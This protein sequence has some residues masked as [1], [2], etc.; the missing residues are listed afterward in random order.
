LAAESYAAIQGYTVQVRRREQVNGQDKPEEV[1]LFKFR[2]QPFSV[3]FKWV[4]P[5]GKDREAIY[6]KG[7]HDDKLHTLLAA[8]DMPFMPAGKRM[9]LSP[10]S[11]F[12][13]S[14][15]RHSVT[16][17]GL[18]TLIDQFG[19]L[20]APCPPGRPPLSKYLGEV[21]RPEFEAPVI[22]VEQTIASGAEPLLP[23]GGTRLWLFDIGTHLP[24]LVSTRD[25]ANH[26]VEYYCYT[27][28]QPANSLTDA[29]FDPEKVWAPRR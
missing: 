13:R 3:Y 20:A 7:Q 18:G 27:S 16:E 19:Q 26:E 10:D 2:K 1:M 8:G 29:D 15:S 12:V 14:A 17:A 6:V 28:F 24:V 25:A 4:G 21:K 22:A 9:S 23:C 11:V 5:V